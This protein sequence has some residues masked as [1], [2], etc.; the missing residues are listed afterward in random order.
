MKTIKEYKEQLKKQKEFLKIM[1][2]NKPIDP[3]DRRKENKIIAFTE[4]EI[5][6][7]KNK[8]NN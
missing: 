3:D 4:C 2:H 5:E 1:Q 8:I 7:L 6:W